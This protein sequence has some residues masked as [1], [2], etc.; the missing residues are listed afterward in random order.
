MYVADQ[1]YLESSIGVLARAKALNPEVLDGHGESQVISVAHVC[2]SAV[3]M[4]G[5]D[6]YGC[7]LENVGGRYDPTCFADLGKEP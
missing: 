2:E 6:V 4:N 1:R 7:L 3:M 5:P